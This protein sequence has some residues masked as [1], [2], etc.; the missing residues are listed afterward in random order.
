[1][2]YRESG[3]PEVRYW[4]SLFDIEAVLDVFG[5]DSSTGAVAEL[6]C[7]YGTFTLPLAQRTGAPV[8]AFDIEPEMAA[9]T[10]AR[11]EAAGMANVA[12]S[13]RDVFAEGF[14]LDSGS[15][16]ACLLFNILHGEAPVPALCEA[17][18]V[19]RPGG[20]VAVIHW[21]SDLA[22]PRGPSL[23]IRPRPEQIVAWAEECGGLAVEGEPQCVGPWH[24]ALRLR[25]L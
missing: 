17:G 4:E 22:T 18:R 9:A 8:H 11:A 5:F 16:G 14:G 21:R 10:R 23:E 2:K 19:V 12:V 24:F 1:M 20:M 6:G 13:M 3:M 7:G 25:K 15:C